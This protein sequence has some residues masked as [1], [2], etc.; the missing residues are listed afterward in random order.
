MYMYMYMLIGV[1]KRGI[2][3]AYEK[4]A[5]ESNNYKVATGTTISI[6]KK[7]IHFIAM[8]GHLHL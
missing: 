5:N 1:V 6:K 2:L 3:H 8:L 4:D 7:T